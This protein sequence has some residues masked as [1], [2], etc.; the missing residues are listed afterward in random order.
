AHAPAPAAG[1]G[2]HALSRSA[3]T[4]MVRIASI[5]RPNRTAR[6]PAAD[7][8]TLRRAAE[9]AAILGERLGLP[10]ARFRVDERLREVF[11]G[12]C[13]GMTAEEIAA[14]PPA[15]WAEHRAGR[16]DAFPGGESRAG[17][18]ARVRAA[19]LEHAAATWAGDLLVVAHRGIV[20]HGLHALL[21]ETG[22]GPDPYAV[23]L[24]SVS[25]VRQ[26]GPWRL[27]ALSLLP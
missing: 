16:A 20:R 3:W 4:P 6:L 8:C 27:E 5:A 24:G 13:E 10:D 15:F 12:D 1:G 9:S 2:V 7:S 21:C 11:F 19:I 23:A 17:F 22:H 14:A 26:D 18:A 25:I